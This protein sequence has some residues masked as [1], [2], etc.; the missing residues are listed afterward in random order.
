MGVR[1]ACC[2]MPW[3]DIQIILP[4]VPPA[5]S[6]VSGMPVPVTDALC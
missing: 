5:N 2:E 4:G 1:T 6:N 3:K